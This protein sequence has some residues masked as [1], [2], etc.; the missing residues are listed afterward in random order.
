MDQ[1][2]KVLFEDNHL[3]VVDKP[4]LLPTMGVGPGEDSLVDLARQ[5]LKYKYHKPGKVYLGV[6]S[7]IDSFV[8]GVIVFARTSKAAAR[9]AKQFSSG[10]T[11]KTYLA[12]VPAK[13]CQPKMRLEHYLAKDEAPAP[14]D[15][16]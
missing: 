12:L 10:L 3:L 13:D 16:R 5:Y 2:L 4:A 6:V 14:H 15:D 11:D 7:R 8:T 9:L 1:S